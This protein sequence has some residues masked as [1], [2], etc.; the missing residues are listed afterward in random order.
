M[1]LLV[2]GYWR[3]KGRTNKR[4]NKADGQWMARRRRNTAKSRSSVVSNMT[5][6]SV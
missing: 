4:A 5:E 3:K 6:L 1:L 2:G